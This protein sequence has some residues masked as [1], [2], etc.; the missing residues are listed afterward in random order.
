MNRSPPRSPADGEVGPGVVAVEAGAGVAL[1]SPLDR[2]D[3][4]VI[5][6]E[7]IGIG[8]SGPVA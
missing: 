2:L 6:D 1:H 8:D 4:L 3:V 7:V 5:G